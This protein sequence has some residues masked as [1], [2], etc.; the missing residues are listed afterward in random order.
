M[1]DAALAIGRP[2][3]AREAALQVIALVEAKGQA[4]G[5][6]PPRAERGARGEDPIEAQLIALRKRLGFWVGFRLRD[7]YA[8]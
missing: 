6:A 8:T 7:S 4:R 3:A 2:E 1:R 5:S